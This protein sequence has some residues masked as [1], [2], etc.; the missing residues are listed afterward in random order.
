MPSLLDLM[1]Y[2]GSQQPPAYAGASPGGSLPIPGFGMG[3]MNA[4]GLG[5][6][7]PGMPG[8]GMGMMGLDLMAGRNPGSS[9]GQ[10]PGQLAMQQPSRYAPQRRRPPQ[11]IG[12]NPNDPYAQPMPWWLGGLPST[13]IGGQSSGR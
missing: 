1:G 12:A 3:G 4:G 8:L 6:T 7:Q 10:A 2:G 5:G 11:Q 13:A 9:P